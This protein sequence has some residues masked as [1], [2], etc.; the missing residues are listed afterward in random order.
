M[1]YNRLADHHAWSN[2]DVLAFADAGLV[3]VTEKDG[4]K[5]RNFASDNFYE[6]GVELEFV[7]GQEFFEQKLFDLHL[8]VRASR[9]EPLWDG[10]SNVD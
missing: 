5:L 9:I 10:V 3:L 8:P 4:V 2:D 7:S 6:I 1:S